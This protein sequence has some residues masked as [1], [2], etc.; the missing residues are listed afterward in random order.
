RTILVYIVVFTVLPL[1]ALFLVFT[2]S[3][4]AVLYK[5]S[6]K[7]NFLNFKA[8]KKQKTSSK[9]RGAKS[10]WPRWS[11]FARRSQQSHDAL[12]A[13][14]QC[15]LALCQ[16]R[17]I[18]F[19]VVP[20]SREAAALAGQLHAALANVGKS[21]GERDSMIA[22]INL[23][24]GFYVGHGQYIRAR[25]RAFAASRKLAKIRMIFLFAFR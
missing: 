11:C 20:M 13:G 4:P 7:D 9:L 12:F 2:L 1:A 6:Y 24:G 19:K 23:H 21:I 14:H 3:R 10:C 17:T 8:I 15:S 25:T 16:S 22:G 18:E 5:F